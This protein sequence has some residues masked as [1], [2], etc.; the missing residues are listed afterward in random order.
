MCQ[1]PSFPATPS[2]LQM[3]SLTATTMPQCVPLNLC[4][5]TVLS[6]LSFSVRYRLRS[7]TLSGSRLL[8]SRVC[9]HR[10]SPLFLKRTNTAQGSMFKA[11]QGDLWLSL[12]VPW[13]FAPPPIWLSKTP[14]RDIFPL[15]DWFAVCI[16]ISPVQIKKTRPVGVPTGL[17]LSKHVI[18]QLSDEYKANRSWTDKAPI[19]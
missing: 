5:S 4:A 8:C 3:R 15:K 17:L 9:P 19:T 13:S 1:L 18:I 12:N 2:L 6:L 16:R 11:L 10:I 14:P 7:T